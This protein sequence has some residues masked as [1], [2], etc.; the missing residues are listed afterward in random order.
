MNKVLRILSF[1]TA[2]TMSLFSPLTV[3][4][5]QGSCCAECI[6]KKEDEIEM[7]YEDEENQNKDE[8]N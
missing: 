6:M 8:E 4:H 1:L 5:G 7:V 3:N 2:T